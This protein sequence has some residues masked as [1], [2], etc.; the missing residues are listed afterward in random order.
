MAGNDFD[1]T[2]QIRDL[3]REK[4]NEVETVRFHPDNGDDS[5]G[6]FVK[7]Y[8]KYLGGLR[9]DY[10]VYEYVDVYLAEANWVETGR[11]KN[12]SP[13]NKSEYTLKIT[14]S[15]TTTEGSET[16]TTQELGF[17]KVAKASFS[18]EDKRISL[19]E[20]SNERGTEEKHYLDPGE[21]LYIYKRIYKFNLRVWWVAD[22]A[23]YLRV[24]TQDAT[25]NT[26]H[27]EVERTIEGDEDIFYHSLAGEKDITLPPATK[28]CDD[29]PESGMVRT[30]FRDLYKRARSQVGGA[31]KRA[32]GGSEDEV[33]REMLSSYA[34]VSPFHSVDSEFRTLLDIGNTYPPPI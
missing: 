7:Q 15:R 10:A 26:H 18:V 16:T 29:D 23:N 14:K 33:K 13:N 4:E 11:R 27:S 9:G 8:K 22:T 30:R 32:Q 25:N 21:E 31:W 2:P 20:T 24:V 12:R 5:R 1:L 34:F 3:L 17:E 28:E 6:L 19:T